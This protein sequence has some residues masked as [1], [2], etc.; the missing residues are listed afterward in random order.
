V[1]LGGRTIDTTHNEKTNPSQRCH[2]FLEH[3]NPVDYAQADQKQ[4]IAVTYEPSKRY[5]LRP[6]FMRIQ[7]T[8]VLC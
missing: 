5:S 8:A 6:S 1:V 2:R 3:L 4:I 7:L